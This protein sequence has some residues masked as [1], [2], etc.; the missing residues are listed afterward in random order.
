MT[1]GTGVTTLHLITPGVDTEMLDAT[2]QVYGTYLDTSGWEKQKPEQWAE[3]VAR[4]IRNDAR[5]LGPGG[6]SAGA[7][8]ASRG[9]AWLLDLASGRMFSRTPRR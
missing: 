7:V 6:K 4:A 1:T 8:L 3:R 5:T 2:E 9:P